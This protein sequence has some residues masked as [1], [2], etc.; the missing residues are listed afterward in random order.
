MYTAT[1]NLHKY[2]AVP[3]LE[4]GNTEPCQDEL[5]K[6][7]ISEGSIF[8]FLAR[9]QP[10]ALEAERAQAEGSLDSRR[11]PP[12]T[13]SSEDT[14]ITGLVENEDQD[15]GTGSDEV[16]PKT[17]KGW[18]SEEFRPT[19][20]RL[21]REL[22]NP[23][24]K[25][26]PNRGGIDNQ[27]SRDEVAAGKRNP[28][29]TGPE[30]NIFASLFQ[31]PIPTNS[32]SP[33]KND[34]GSQ[35]PIPPP[36]QHPAH[37]WDDQ[38]STS[39]APNPAV[40]PNMSEIPKYTTGAN[41][42]ALANSCG[43][44]GSGGRIPGLTHSD[45]PADKSTLLQ[46]PAPQD[47]G[48]TPAFSE[49]TMAQAKQ[50]FSDQPT[51]N[52][53]LTD[54]YKAPTTG[55]FGQEGPFIKGGLFGEPKSPVAKASIS[56]DAH[57]SNPQ[58]L[59]GGQESRPDN[60]A[61]ATE[62]NQRPYVSE[63]LDRIHNLE[64]D[65]ANALITG[66][67]Y[68]EKLETVENESGRQRTE[69]R[70]KMD[71]KIAEKDL[72]KEEALNAQKMKYETRIQE[73]A[74]TELRH[75]KATTKLDELEKVIQSLERENIDLNLA[76]TVI[77]KEL[78]DLEMQSGQWKS[79]KDG[80]DQIK[81]QLE[82][83][84]VSYNDLVAER[85]EL[86]EKLQTLEAGQTKM[87][88]EP[89]TAALPGSSA[90]PHQFDGRHAINSDRLDNSI[91]HWENR[92]KTAMTLVEKKREEIASYDSEI[93]ILR[94]N[95]VP[96]LQPAPQPAQKFLSRQPPTA[97]PASFQPLDVGI[98]PLTVE[99]RS[100]TDASHQAFGQVGEPS[101]PPRSTSAAPQTWAARVAGQPSS[102]RDALPL[103]T[104]AAESRIHDQQ[105]TGRRGQPKT[106]RVQEYEWHD[107]V[108][109]KRAGDKS[110]RRK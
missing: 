99:K 73:A 45:L 77:E 38:G 93:A 100:E 26:G 108:G 91:K 107:V 98:L 85:D 35:V 84:Q 103:P 67:F 46:S 24:L 48:K 61:S 29:S 22:D 80:Y 43:I 83:L 34:S 102:T 20:E 18:Y 8:S 47:D 68:R 14:H 101:I 65:K 54:G 75:K 40:E 71:N 17:L 27:H 94:G 60:A 32:P 89:T 90:I 44:T 2:R 12:Q 30:N 41:I 87:S 37:S 3:T 50:Y 74:A 104:Q 66:T 7:Y 105:N 23:S 51:G 33:P 79:Y 86:E 57:V 10:D 11:A 96:P 9:P 53:L 42:F 69:H 110:G 92:L 28:I 55:P 4:M 88:E 15:A 36:S 109:N 72:E 56:T 59:F 16:Y 25:E 62:I 78:K 76:K 49:S 95:P 70:K 64:Q 19:R 5:D 21:Q 31:P 6:A 81:H 58:F 39:P 63:L 106:E 82:S 52:Q 1:T 13:S 97:N